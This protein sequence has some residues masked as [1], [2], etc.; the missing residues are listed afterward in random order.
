M[1]GNIKEEW[2][3]ML[4]GIGIAAILTLLVVGI[5]FYAVPSTHNYYIVNPTETEI[6]QM[7]QI[8]NSGFVR[9]VHPAQN[10][11]INNDIIVPTGIHIV[12]VGYGISCSNKSSIE[13]KFKELNVVVYDSIDKAIIAATEVGGQ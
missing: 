11:V 2:A 12:K 6:S 3:Y 5:S 7:N 4:A 9:W 8:G 10:V 13:H 1:I